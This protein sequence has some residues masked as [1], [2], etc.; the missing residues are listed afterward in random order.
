[1]RVLVVDD[2]PE[3][4]TLVARHLER[5]SH[6]VVAVG[7]SAAAAAALSEAPFDVVVLDVMLPDGSGVELC[8]RWRADGVEVPI[9]LLT[10]RGSVRSRVEGL[11]AGADDYL[12]KPF[13]LSELG[14]R[15][16]ALGR[17]GPRLRERVVKVG[18]LV[19]ELDARRVRVRDKT[20]ALTAKELSIVEFLA[21]R[22]NRVVARDELIEGVWGDLS[23]SARASLDVLV[24]RIRRKLGPDAELLRTVRGLGYALES[25]T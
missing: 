11:E 10:A 20:I 5:A 22:R 16:T 15:V 9:L 13:A 8:A 21:G 14:A 19:V 25:E 2:H 4:R 24:M 7:S 1:M 18:P 6:G 3:T 12:G 23:E 17:R